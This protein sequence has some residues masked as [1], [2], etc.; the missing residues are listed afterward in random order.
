MFHFLI[1]FINDWP[2]LNIEVIF[3]EYV[4]LPA[5]W[6]KQPVDRNMPSLKFYHDLSSD[7]QSW[8]M[9]WGPCWDP[10]W[11]QVF[12]AEHL[13]FIYMLKMGLQKEAHFGK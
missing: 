7:V 13:L 11:S 12:I 3:S 5:P 8:H 9:A 2:F 6:S 1:H 10:A 4:P